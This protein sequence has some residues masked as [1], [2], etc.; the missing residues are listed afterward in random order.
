MTTAA[1]RAE[2]FAA[3]GTTINVVTRPWAPEALT[4]A[5]E[6]I[7]D[8]D[9]GC[10]RFRSDSELSSVNARPG[11]WVPVGPVL[12]GAL[13]VALEAAQNS[14][15]LVTPC[16]GRSLRSLGYDADL[17]LVRNRPDTGPNPIPHVRRDAWREIEIDSAGA[18]RIPGDVELDL[19]ATGKAFAADLAA[20][21]INEQLSIDVAVSAGGDVRIINDH[22]D[23]WPIEI[24]ERPES[25]AGDLI[26]V[27]DGGVATSSTTRRRWTH[28]GVVR[29][30]LIDPRTGVPSAGPWRT[31]TATGPTCAAANVAATAAIILGEDAI[32]WLD[33]RGIWARLVDQAG[34]A[35]TVGTATGA[36]S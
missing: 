34:R 18:V 10:S 4:I 29:H 21:T 8:I 7:A 3:I 17:D 22:G 33:E 20:L 11:R 2:S 30:H 12:L 35:T 24:A 14:D 36:A 16:L 25:P 1:P 13:R 26:H 5:R 19:G 15:G 27:A 32:A 9:E 28:A 31:V 6:V 23:L